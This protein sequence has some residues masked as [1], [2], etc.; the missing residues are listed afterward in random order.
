MKG[1]YIKLILEPFNRA[2][3]M[4]FSSSAL[5]MA[6]PIISAPII[7]R[8]YTPEDFG[9][10]AVFFSLATIISSISSLEL[11]NIALIAS[12][13][14][15]AAH[16]TLLALV[17]V[18]L[19]SLF[20]GFFVL[21]LPNAWLS[22]LVGATVLSYLIFLPLTVFFM[23][24]TQVLFSWAIREKE[25]KKLAK[26]KLILGLSTMVLQIGV[27]L[28][29]PGAIGFIVA[30]IIGLLMVTLLLSNLFIRDLI[31]LRPKFTI[32]SSFVQLRLHCSLIIWTMPGSLINSLCQF[33]PEI[34]INRFFGS[35][36]LGQYS[37]AMRMINIPISFLST[38]MQDIF[39]QQASAEFNETGNIRSSFFR[40]FVIGLIGAAVIIVPL[41][42]FIPY[43]LP[44]IFGAQWT[45]AGVLIQ[46]I[47]F[48]SVVRFISS[49]LSYIWIIRG[50]QKLDFLW[51]VGLLV[52]SILT[53]F[54]YPLIHP[55]VSL[56]STLWIYSFVVG[57]WYLLAI[58]L[59]YH[60]SKIQRIK[61]ASVAN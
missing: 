34:L 23:G 33:L 30:N 20:I 37:L 17:V 57:V 61:D 39:R 8:L 51:Q 26:N 1:R 44:I 49:P 58:F 6:F 56:Y 53:L 36:L 19:F 10:Y 22:L 12:E 60:L 55:K 11:R 28:T 40:F 5:V 24:V 59:S 18:G 42:S 52:L 7:A 14:G 15:D 46:A 35:V 41:I 47:F 2:H 38:S 4:F 21:F 48:L 27:G 29:E 25:Y 54:F 45:E 3:A 13:R 31:V 32:K 50:K 16:G 43:M 9:I